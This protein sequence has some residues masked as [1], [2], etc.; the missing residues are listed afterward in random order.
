MSKYNEDIVIG[1]HFS[2]WGSWWNEELGWGFKC[3]HANDKRSYC[4]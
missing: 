4:L 3:C 2:V 1:N